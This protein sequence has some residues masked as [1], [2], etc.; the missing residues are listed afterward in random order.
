MAKSKKSGSKV[1]AD[2]YTALLVI[3]LMALLVGT[4]VLYLETSDY[5]TNKTGGA[6]SV[7]WD[8]PVYENSSDG[9]FAESHFDH[10]WRAH[11]EQ[12]IG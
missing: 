9:L 10:G 12:P 5:G 6:P 4:V 3:A 11:P 1:P 2:L 7:T 8:Q